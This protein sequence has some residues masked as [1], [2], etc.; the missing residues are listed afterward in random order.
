M[1]YIFNTYYAIFVRIDV[2]CNL[3]ILKILCKYIKNII[4]YLVY[5]DLGFRELIIVLSL[6]NEN[7]YQQIESVRYVVMDLLGIIGPYYGNI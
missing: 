1:I 7:L 4:I 5:L 2:I 6:N 3:I